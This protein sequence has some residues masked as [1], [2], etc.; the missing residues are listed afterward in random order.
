MSTVQFHEVPCP[1]T[2][3]IRQQFQIS[4]GKLFGFSTSWVYNPVNVTPTNALCRTL[5]QVVHDLYTSNFGALMTSEKSLMETT[6]VDLNSESGAL[7]AYA[8]NNAGSRGGQVLNPGQVATVNYTIQRHYRG[9]RG[10]TY[11]PI[12]GALDTTD[13]IHWTPA[14]I[15]TFNTAIGNYLNGIGTNGTIA[16]QFQVVRSY[17]MG[18]QPNPD[19][20]VWSTKYEPLPRTDPNNPGKTLPVPYQAIQWALN[21]RIG[22]QQ[23]RAAP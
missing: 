11:L 21:P 2:V 10:R 8:S 12:G 22:S 4:S 17:F 7:G 16:F 14:A 23:R 19:P 20:S 15:G 3:R 18:H 6:V 9:G 5:A 1:Y 13:N